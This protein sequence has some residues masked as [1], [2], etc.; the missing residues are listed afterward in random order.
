MSLDQFDGVLAIRLVLVS[1]AGTGDLLVV[2]CAEVPPPFTDLV[3][4]DEPV[5]DA[6][7]IRHDVLLL[8]G[9]PPTGMGSEATPIQYWTIGIESDGVLPGSYDQDFAR[10]LLAKNDGP[11][12]HP[13]RQP[14][15]GGSLLV[16]PALAR[17]GVLDGLKQSDQFGQRPDMIS[18]ARCDGRSGLERGVDHVRLLDPG[19]KGLRP[20]L[21]ALREATHAT[22][23]QHA[24]LDAYTPSQAS[25]QRQKAMDHRRKR[26]TATAP[27]SR[28]TPT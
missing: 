25:R 2:G 28:T 15:F 10:L 16:R 22:A 7:P 26:R 11:G 20:Q 3:L 12:W 14:L 9:S 24:R 27:E 23:R 18:D 1:L 5:V 4:E 19:R 8:A 13:G 17:L 21:Y 6:W